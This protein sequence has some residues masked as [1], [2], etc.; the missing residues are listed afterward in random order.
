MT[1]PRVLT[2]REIEPGDRVAG[3][4][5]GNSAFTPLKSFLRNHAQSFHTSNIAKSYVLV[6]LDGNRV[7]GYVTLM[8]SEVTLAGHK[9]EDCPHA[10]GYKTYPAVKIA[11][12]AI[13]QSL[14][15]SGYG[16][17]LIDWSISVAQNQ[18]MPH[19]GCRFVIVDSK[20][21]SMR[22][23]EKSGFTFLDTEKNRDSAHPL[24]FLDLH[25]LGF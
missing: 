2:L 9:F 14:Q 4:S 3:L 10:T 15:G 17:A 12:L 8:S 1:V 24:M 19:I 18:I 25:K 11:R 7:Y 21:E 16:R 20:R 5:L 22:F 6:P 23:Y 13:D